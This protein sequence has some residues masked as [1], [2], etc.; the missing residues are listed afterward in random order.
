MAPSNLS[1]ALLTPEEAHLYQ[2]IRHETFRTTINKILYSREPSQAT[3]DHVV[4]KH[5]QDIADGVF[6]L[7]CRDNDTGEMIA[8]AR[9]R[10]V[11]P[12]EEGKER[13]W[14]EVDAGLTV[15]EP[16]EESEPGAWKALF[17]L[18]NQNKRDILGTKPYYVLDTLVTHPDHHRKGAGGLLV[19]WGCNKADEKGVVAYLEA[20]EMG[21]PLYER[22]GFQPVKTVSVDL[23]DFGGDEIMNFIVSGI[24]HATRRGILIA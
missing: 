5:K 18:F 4:A 22:Y 15:P 8:G 13:T 20:S 17:T 10:Y 24:T 12:K 7:G 1:I 23:K 21:K 19:Q 6:Y 16:Y 2:A 3:L 11:G 9:W 14:G